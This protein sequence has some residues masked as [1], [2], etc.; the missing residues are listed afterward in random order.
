MWRLRTAGIIICAGAIFAAAE[1]AG[2]VING[3]SSSLGRYTVRL[4]GNGNCTGVAVARHAVVTAAHCAA[5][6]RVIA[7]GASLRV[8][9]ITHSAT[10]DDGRVLRASGDA[11]ILL[12]KEELPVGVALAPVGDGDGSLFTIAGYGTTDESVRDSGFGELNEAHLIAAGHG[13]LT[14]PGGAGASACFGDSGGPVF[15]GGALVGVITRASNPS[16]RAACGRITRWA[17]LSV[18]GTAKPAR[19]ARTFAAQGG[20]P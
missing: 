6:M 2:A 15:R 4:I 18:G 7:R 1:P 5:G 11:A 16:P 13:M 12:L 17:P 14:D 8:R 20:T 10:L 9:Q 3:V 19:T